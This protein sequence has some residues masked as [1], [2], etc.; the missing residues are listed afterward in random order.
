MNVGI[1]IG[2]SYSSICI[3]NQDGNAE[4]VHVST[5]MSVFGDNYSSLCG[6]RQDQYWT[7]CDD[8]QIE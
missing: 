1:D 6:K 3:L 2:T 7:S 8:F 5:G 4:P